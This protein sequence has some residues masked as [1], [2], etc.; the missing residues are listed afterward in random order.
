M[1]SS[2][3]LPTL[4]I[5]MQISSRSRFSYSVR[6]PII[7]GVCTIISC[8]LWV[9]NP[10]DREITIEHLAKYGLESRL[11]GHREAG[12]VANTIELKLAYCFN[13]FRFRLCLVNQKTNQK[14][15]SV[16]MQRPIVAFFDPRKSRIRSELSRHGTHATACDKTCTQTCNKIVIFFIIIMLY[17]WWQY[18]T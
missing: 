14:Q 5:H 17:A 6:R 4:R 3:L 7:F 13:K 10:S 15:G 18:T 12:L 2:F 9:T 16:C 11:R 1:L 8:A